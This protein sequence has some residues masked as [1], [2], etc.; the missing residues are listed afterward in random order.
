M[1]FAAKFRCYTARGGG[2]RTEN[3]NNFKLTFYTYRSKK[4]YV[5]IFL[6]IFLFEPRQLLTFANVNAKVKF[7]WNEEL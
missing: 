1:F 6:I 5:R 2:K 7:V 4:V 3:G